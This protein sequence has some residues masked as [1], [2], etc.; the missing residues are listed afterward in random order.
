MNPGK[1]A[2]Y[3]WI[4]TICK[5]KYFTSGAERVKWNTQTHTYLNSQYSNPTAELCKLGI[6]LQIRRGSR[7]SY[8]PALKKVGLY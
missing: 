8:S 6:M 2:H 1:A 5:F 4:H 7:D 3:E